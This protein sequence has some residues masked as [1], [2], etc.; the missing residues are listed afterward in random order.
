M[1]DSKATKR[2]EVFEVGFRRGSYD[3]LE[4]AFA[5]CRRCYEYSYVVDNETGEQHHYGGPVSG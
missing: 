4:E 2:F 3:T 5:A 1:N